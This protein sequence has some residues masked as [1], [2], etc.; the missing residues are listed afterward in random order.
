MSTDIKLSKVQISKII[1]L[2]VSYGSVLDNLDKKVLTNV[3]IPF[4][5]DNLPGLARKITLNAVIK[6]QRKVNG[7]RDAKAWPAF[8][9]ISNEG[10]ND[11]IEMIKSPEVPN[12]LTD[13]VTET[14]KHEIKHKKVEFLVLF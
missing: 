12:V 14:V 8:A 1:K 4:D 7:K 11:I 2:D 9:F 5:R 3:G 6:C 13:D 10:L